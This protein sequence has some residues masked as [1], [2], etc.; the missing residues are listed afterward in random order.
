[1]GYLLKTGCCHLLEMI[2]KLRPKGCE[3]GSQN[4]WLFK[5]QEKCFRQ[6]PP[7]HAGP[8]LLCPEIFLLERDVCPL[9][10]PPWI[11]PVQP[12]TS[13][14]TYSEDCHTP[15]LLC[16]RELTSLLPSRPHP[17]LLC[18][19]YSDLR[20]LWLLESSISSNLSTLFS[21][22]FLPTQ[23]GHSRWLKT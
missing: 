20:D 10:A 12:P 11:V 18:N 17:Y 5:T 15:E 7:T 8:T 3:G 9:H 22:L 19:L 6:V 16:V 2:Y 1:M 21:R 13:W 23:P 14:T 4:F